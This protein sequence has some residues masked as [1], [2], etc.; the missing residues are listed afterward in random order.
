MGA[1][2][3]INPAPLYYKSMPLDDFTLNILVDLAS[4]HQN[5]VGDLQQ[6]RRYL[7]DCLAKNNKTGD[8]AKAYF[9][10][11]MK[12]IEDK[13]KSVSEDRPP[14]PIRESFDGWYTG[15]GN[16]SPL[17]HR[18]KQTLE[19]KRWTKELIDQMDHSTNTIVGMM[20]PPGVP[21]FD[22]K[23]LAVGRVQ[24][25]KTGNFIGVLA[26]AADAGYKMIIVLGGTTNT[27]RYQTQDRIQKDLIA[28]G[29]PGWN[30]LTRAKVEEGS[31]KIQPGDFGQFTP[32]AGEPAVSSSETVMAG[33]KSIGVVKKNAKVLRDLK[34]WVK[35]TTPH[36]KSQCPVLIIDD[37][38]DQ[39]SVNSADPDSNPTT[40]NRLIREII[41]LLPKVTYIGYTATPFAN[42]FIDPE[43]EGDLYPKDFIVSLPKSEFYFGP[44][45]IFG[46][47]PLTGETTGQPGANILREISGPDVECVRPPSGTAAA[48]A[49]RFEIPPTLSKAIVYFILNSAARIWR[50]KNVLNE[51]GKG[52]FKSMLI[53]T[54]QKQKIHSMTMEKVQPFVSQLK[55]DF[56]AGKTDASWSKLWM[57]E[58]EK[59][60]S[61]E[62]GCKHPKVTYDQLKEHLQ[63]TLDRI[64]VIKSNSSGEQVSNLNEVYH[65]NNRGKI[66]IVIGGNTLARGITLEG[67]TVS[68]FVREAS[69]FDTLLQMGR[70]FGYRKDYEDMPRVWMTAQ[71]MKDFFDLATIE[72]EFFKILEPYVLGLSPREVGPKIRQHPD[73]LPTAKSKMR[74]AIECNIS[75]TGHLI[76]T[77]YFPR[78]DSNW[79]KAN[80]E[81]GRKLV[82]SLGG[83]AAFADNGRSSFVKTD[84]A[85]ENII[86]FLKQ[87]KVNERNKRF[88][89][90]NVISYLETALK[91]K[92]HQKW[93]V[94]LRSNSRPGSGTTD[95]GIPLNNLNI[96]PVEAYPDKDIAYIKSLR[97]PTDVICDANL[98]Q[99]AGA[100]K[101]RREEELMAFRNTY[102]PNTGLLILYPLNKD[103]EGNNEDRMSMKAAENI[104]GCAIYFA[105]GQG[106]PHSYLKVQQECDAAPDE[107]SDEDETTPPAPQA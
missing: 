77:T 15:P 18:Y 62:V 78:E 92:H 102:A 103:A 44:E 57:E 82:A 50:E 35:A 75:Y 13:I 65:S 5:K 22:Y 11:V 2:P 48:Q 76:E 32:T 33:Q 90:S 98:G 61:N 8:E 88:S 40:I 23:G 43:V 79:L 67:L 54:S 80:L 6:T 60:N 104:L 100:P 99:A 63:E 66:V 55:S 31:L 45:R 30:W 68:Y 17:W 81:A 29:D 19:S 51:T 106:S 52:E 27:L 86:G 10:A 83:A 69:A 56:A 28:L 36:A 7:E 46:R 12:I 25:G 26:K 4:T 47:D 71:M 93:N 94:V 58:T 3:G 59:L 87:Y 49:F 53:N 73:Y 72:F 38:C 91:D 37:E 74:K 21:K 107:P 84:V 39:A 41:G 85:L 96:A 70:W 14:M 97:S 64:E 20:A 95:I 9:D 24:S 101:A 42:V 1:F 89:Q 105:Q 34:A 16:M